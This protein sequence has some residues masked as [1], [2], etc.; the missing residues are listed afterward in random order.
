MKVGDLVAW[1]FVRNDQDEFECDCG[2]VL[3]ISQTGHTTQSAQ[4]LF[5]DGD[6]DWI[7][8]RNLKVINESG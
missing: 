5:M 8:T 7:D 4:V 3:Q 6:V 1:P 2:I